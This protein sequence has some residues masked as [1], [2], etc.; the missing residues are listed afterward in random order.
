MDLVVITV[1][2]PIGTILK[3]RPHILAPFSPS[4]MAMDKQFRFGRRIDYGTRFFQNMLGNRNKQYENVCKLQM[5]VR[6]KGKRPSVLIDRP[7]RTPSLLA[8]ILYATVHIYISTY[9][10]AGDRTQPTAELTISI[11]RPHKCDDTS[12]GR[13]LYE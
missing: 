1:C 8:N 13:R 12:C 3:T 6:K 2:R 7:E 4:N 11:R 10:S 5:N 9:L